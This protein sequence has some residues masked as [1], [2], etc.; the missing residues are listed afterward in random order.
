MSDYP[1]RFYFNSCK[2]ILLAGHVQSMMILHDLGNGSKFKK[3][4]EVS[5]LVFLDESLNAKAVTLQARMKYNFRMI[6]FETDSGYFSGMVSTE[7]K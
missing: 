1:Y 3:A 4:A 7:V 2:R 5:V 6:R